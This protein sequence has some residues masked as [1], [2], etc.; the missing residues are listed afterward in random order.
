MF[1][2]K[3]NV[4]MKPSYLAH[5]E[6]RIRK[7]IG[8]LRSWKESE[9]RSER[10]YLEHRKEHLDRPELSSCE[11]CRRNQVLLSLTHFSNTRNMKYK[12]YFVSSS[13]HF[14]G[15]FLPFFS[16][17][18]SQLTLSSAAFEYLRPLKF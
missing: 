3:P 7:E 16:T 9:L 13:T 5:D 2:T 15:H 14:K 6:F 8:E 4:K 11:H 12:G 17:H 10:Q 1:V 18:D